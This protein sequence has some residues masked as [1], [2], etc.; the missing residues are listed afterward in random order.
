MKGIMLSLLMLTNVAFLSLPATAQKKSKE[1]EQIVQISTDYGDIKIRLYNETPL[2]RDNFI[3]LASEGKYDGS[4]FHRVISGFMIQGGGAPGSGG[5]DSMG[6]LIPAE[7]VS[8]YLHKKGALAAARMG[9]NVNPEKKSSGSQF[10]IVQGKKYSDTDLDNMQK[11]PGISFS[12][13]QRRAY[14]TIGGT[15]HLDHNYTVFGEVIEGLD[16]VDKIAAV[17]TNRSR[18]VKDIKMTVTVVK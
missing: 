6:G 12:E 2:H 16:V 11:R 13:E 1:K 17:E 14:R 7:F 15:P 18:P 5:E 9:D 10:Y 4:I 3:K 8:K